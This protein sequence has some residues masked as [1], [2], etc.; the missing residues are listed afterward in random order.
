MNRVQFMKAGIDLT[1]DLRIH[2]L[3]L[4]N[5]FKPNA[6]DGQ[7]VTVEMEVR[8]PKAGLSPLLLLT[9]IYYA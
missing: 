3:M 8:S 4:D 7:S 2:I 5:E 1:Q 9:H 6:P